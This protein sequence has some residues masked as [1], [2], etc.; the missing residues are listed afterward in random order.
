MSE[1]DNE[2]IWRGLH[3]WANAIETGNISLSAEDAAKYNAPS[4]ALP[5]EIQELVVRIR[6]VA[7]KHR[8]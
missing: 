5:K 1:N 6:A 8:S 3:A 2:L 7:E 4:Y